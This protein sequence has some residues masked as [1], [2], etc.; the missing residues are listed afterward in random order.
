MNPEGDTVEVAI[1]LGN[2]WAEIHTAEDGSLEL[3]IVFPG[4]DTT[5]CPVSEWSRYRDFIDALIAK[6]SELT[7]EVGQSLRASPLAWDSP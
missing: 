6:H 5:Y 7:A 3:I 1:T 2:T 4:V